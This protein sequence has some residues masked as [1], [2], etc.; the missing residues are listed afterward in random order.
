MKKTKC[1]KRQN[2]F[3][4]VSIINRI[5]IKIWTL[6]IGF[7]PHSFLFTNP[8]VPY[9]RKLGWHATL[10]NPQVIFDEQSIR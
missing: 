1:K 3:G 8:A 6:E 4:E 5:I 10:S 2:S 7:E 9:W